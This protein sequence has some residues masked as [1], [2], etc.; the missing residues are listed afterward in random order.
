MQQTERAIILSDE[1]NSRQVREVA[2][3]L[4]TTNLHIL[5]DLVPIAEGID[6]FLDPI[7][8]TRRAH[9][10]V[11]FAN[12]PVEMRDLWDKGEMQVFRFLASRPL[13]NTP[14]R[15]DQALQQQMDTFHFFVSF[16][17]LLRYFK[18]KKKSVE[19]LLS[20]LEHNRSNAIDLA[21]STYG[22]S[23]TLRFATQ[24]LYLAPRGQFELVEI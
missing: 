15:I 1:W 2:F 13:H 9:E 8:R 5:E 18:S 6:P 17:D 12:I 16:E 22:E 19:N 20:N 14:G 7:L 4:A 3:N 21:Y 10:R 11:I 23:R 24:G